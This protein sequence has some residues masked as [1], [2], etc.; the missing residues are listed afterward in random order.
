MA[1]YVRQRADN[2]KTGSNIDPTYLN[3]E[4]NQIQAAF[5]ASTGHSHNGS[6]SGE[7]PKLVLTSAAAVSGTLPLANGGTGA[8]TA[9]AARTNLGFSNTVV[10]T[11]VAVSSAVATGTTLVPFDDTIPQ[12]TEGDEYITIAFTPTSAT[13]TL[14]IFASLM[15]ANSAAGNMT[16]ALFQDSTANA[17]AATAHRFG[18]VDSPYTVS[19]SHTMTSGTTSSTT[20]KIR[21]GSDTAGTTTF[22]GTAG[23]RKFSTLSKSRIF[24]LE[25]I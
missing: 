6:S 1:G 2:I 25:I 9:A 20:F 13:S 3:D 10:K 21:A 22:N 14:Y 11:G 17:L 7:G 15:L 4:Y 8:T 19:L 24:I 12:N 16:L 5:H 23:A 18:T